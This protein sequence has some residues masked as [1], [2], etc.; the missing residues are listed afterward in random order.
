MSP[1]SG[2]DDDGPS[3][4]DARRGSGA[5]TPA[6]TRARITSR[7]GGRETRDDPRGDTRIVRPRS[8]R[9]APGAARS[10][11][12][13]RT[14]MIGPAAAFLAAPLDPRS[15][16]SE[17]KDPGRELASA[18]AFVAAVARFCARIVASPPASGPAF[19]SHAPGSTQV[20]R[21]NLRLKK[22]VR[23]GRQPKERG[24]S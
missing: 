10:A 13:A 18:A 11:P 6:G 5:S 14:V 2:G 21:G 4:V 19:A 15:S 9:G 16:R 22:H 24:A 7:R 12:A 17:S 3:S 20:G 8:L 23:V 1:R